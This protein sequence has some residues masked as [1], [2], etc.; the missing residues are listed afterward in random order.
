MFA[1][2]NVPIDESLTVVMDTTLNIAKIMRP[3]ISEDTLKCKVLAFNLKA[4]VEVLLL[5]DDEDSP[6]EIN[7]KQLALG[8]LATADWISPSELEDW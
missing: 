2:S 5:A 8:L 3:D 6:V 4:L 1:D 7:L